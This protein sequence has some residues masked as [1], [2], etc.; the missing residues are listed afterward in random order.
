MGL[1]I[2]ILFQKFHHTWHA[3]VQHVRKTVTVV[4]PFYVLLRFNDFLCLANFV[5][6]FNMSAHVISSVQKNFA[7]ECILANRRIDGRSYDEARNVT[8]SL[9]PSWGFAEVSFENT[10]AVAT[11]VV[12][13]V[14]PFSDR[15]NDGILSIT[16]GLSPTSSQ[17][18]ATED[19]HHPNST[20]QNASIRT[21][22]ETFVRDSRTL[23]TEALCILAGVM[24]WSVKVHVD[25]INDDGNAIDV[26]VM[27][28]MASLL[29]ARRPDF[30]VVGKEVRIHSLFER[31]PLPLPIHHVS[32]SVSLALFG[33]R[34]L[35]TVKNIVV[36]PVKTEELSSN[37][38]LTLAFNAHGEMCGFYKAGG[39]PVSLL[40]IT[41]LVELGEVQVVKYVQILKKALD[42][43]LEQNPLQMVKPIWVTRQSLAENEMSKSEMKVCDME[44]DAKSGPIS[45]WNATP[46]Q[47]SAPP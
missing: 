23:D 46:V 24:V 19:M 10:K 34:N 18:A 15:S 25:I 16:V 33:K 43:V 26:S 22:V 31:N 3:C 29:H 14:V 8:I 30:T 11:T 21:C 5:H 17:F 20:A 35:S 28:V 42:D 6:A 1:L 7:I 47:D 9:G 36:D 40:Q 45:T 37:G 32:L 38:S 2:I 12:E 13:P 41:Q 27:A 4:Y 44:T 39:S